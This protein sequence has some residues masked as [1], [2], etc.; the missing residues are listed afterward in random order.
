MTLRQ[1]VTVVGI[2]GLITVPGG[3]WILVLEVGESYAHLQCGNI[4]F[5]LHMDS[6]GESWI[7]FPKKEYLK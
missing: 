1:V 3:V 2:G 4:Y 5:V 7:P 6:S